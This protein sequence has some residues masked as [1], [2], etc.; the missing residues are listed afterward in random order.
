GGGNRHSALLITS[1]VQPVTTVDRA[2]VARHPRPTD[3]DPRRHHLGA[4]HDIGD[5]AP[6]LAVRLVYAFV[7]VEYRQCLLDI[8]EPEELPR[9]LSV[10]SL[11]APGVPMPLADQGIAGEHGRL[12]PDHRRADQRART[13]LSPAG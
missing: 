7:L 9:H 11:D 8:S 10:G 3:I 6:V 1:P 4:H 2:D 5:H 12:M 13:S